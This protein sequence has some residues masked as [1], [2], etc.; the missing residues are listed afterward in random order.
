M[1]DSGRFATYKTQR[2]E[3]KPKLYSRSESVSRRWKP[4]EGEMIAKTRAIQT[5]MLSCIVLAIA[6][7]GEW[8][9]HY[10]E[11]RKNLIDNRKEFLRMESVLIDSGYGLIRTD[12]YDTVEVGYEVDGE[13]EYETIE[14]DKGWGD[15]LS[16]MNVHDI[17][18]NDG[19]FAFGINFSYESDRYVDYAYH[20]NPNA[21]S[22]YLVCH[23]SHEQIPCG[24]CVKK[25]IDEWWVYYRWFPDFFN[26]ERYESL[27]DGKITQEEYDR[28]VEQEISEC[29]SFGFSA[30]GY[31]R[32]EA[33]E[34]EPRNSR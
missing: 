34:W 14:D 31:Q 18:V 30:Q 11:I 27:M 13:A 20:H 6:G 7:C 32:N 15:R 33:G 25:L 9:P 4:G 8:P 3:E 5:V 16:R 29:W 19:S 28:A 10:K 17:Y 12:M 23:P 21:D 2:H 1:P 24:V 22:I 26:L